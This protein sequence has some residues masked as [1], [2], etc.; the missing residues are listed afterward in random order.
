M[1][2]TCRHSDRSQTMNRSE[3]TSPGAPTP[4]KLDRPVRPCDDDLVGHVPVNRHEGLGARH[5][6][7]LL[8]PGVGLLSLPRSSHLCEFSAHRS[9][10]GRGLPA[11]PL[12]AR[13]TPRW[14]LEAPA[15]VLR[16]QGGFS[17]AIV[18]PRAPVIPVETGP[19]QTGGDIGF[20]HHGA[21]CIAAYAFLIAERARLSPPAPLA[22]LQA[23]PVPRGFRPRGSP[24]KT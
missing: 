1:K 9:P 16:I 5:S 17:P 19:F 6:G 10:E 3:S 23:P 12:R 7:S 20:H 21:L 11:G 18:E 2:N 4:R 15:P 14:R 13:P 22:F 8:P 24:A